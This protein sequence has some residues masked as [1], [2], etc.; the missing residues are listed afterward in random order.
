VSATA[1]DAGHH[2]LIGQSFFEA[3]DRVAMFVLRGP[4]GEP[5]DDE[6]LLPV[7]GIG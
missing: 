3:E 5:L 6:L 2:G 7:G 1:G 4:G